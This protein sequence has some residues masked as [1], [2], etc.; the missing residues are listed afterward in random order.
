MTKNFISNNITKKELR[1]AICKFAKVVGIKT[2]TF[3]N[4]SK[5]VSGSYN[6]STKSLFLDNTLDKKQLLNVFFHELGH[7][8]AI[9][10][11]MWI[12]YHY[13][14]LNCIDPNEAFYIEN[15]IDQIGK[16]LWY[17]YVD[18]K[19]WGMYKYS[20]PKSQKKFLIKNTLTNRK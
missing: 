5:Y 3:N 14:P 15:Q 18:I 9:K 13:T 4:K 2:I 16:K 12:S 10:Q 19:Q 1:T 17:K 20:Y 8:E 7:H 6:A 11:E